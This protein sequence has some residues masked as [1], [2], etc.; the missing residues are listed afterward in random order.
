MLVGVRPQDAEGR[1]D[2][3][4]HRVRL[5]VKPIHALVVM[6]VLTVLLCASLT[7]LV[8]QAMNFSVMEGQPIAARKDSTGGG[9]K[10]DKRLD[11]SSQG[12]GNRRDTHTDDA[13]D[14]MRD[15]QSHGQTAPSLVPSDSGT[16]PGPSSADVPSVPEASAPSSQPGLDLNTASESELQTLRGVGPV[17]ARAIVMYRNTIGRFTSVD[18]LLQVDGIGPKTLEKLRSQVHV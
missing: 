5:V 1:Y 14:A 2:K 10:A 3:P 7:M 15:G 12:N 13:T 8:Q 6:L 4:R 11:G 9:G 16:Q 17:T 18:Q